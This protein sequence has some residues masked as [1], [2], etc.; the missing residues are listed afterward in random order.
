VAA[1]AASLLPWLHVKMLPAALA[2][3][4]VAVARLRGRPRV[5]FAFTAGLMA[6]LFALYYQIVFGRP[7]PL[8]IY[9]GIPTDVSGS[10]GRAVAGLGLDRSFGLLT[11]APLFLL[12]VPGLARLFGR[13]RATWPVLFVAAAVLLPVLPWRMWWGGQCPPG[14]F[15]VPL[16]P[17]LALA[18]GFVAAGER[19][20]LQRWRVPL[21]ALGWALGVYMIHD[22]G[23]L[24]LLNRANRPSRLWT[25]LSADV[26]VGPYLPSLTLP[27]PV[28]H[29]VAA[30][31]AA[32]L[33][34]VLLLHVLAQRK[35]AFDR[36]FRSFALPVALLVAV[37]AAVDGWARRGV[38][39][40]GAAP[41]SP[42]LE[43]SQAS[44]GPA[45]LEGSDAFL[46]R[47][48]QHDNRRV[49]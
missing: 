43:V 13:W 24:L 17:V 4:L 7:T 39:D 32:A 19:R 2:L 8:A 6:I 37:G 20:G 15:L 3:G 34:L 44:P 36:V 33:G 23:A 1:A 28:E 40:A 38:P 14:R 5:A 41:E 47:P 49:P 42:A 48:G 22:P 45:G 16:L 9:G 10:P 26:A 35:D 11:H 31:W 25:A 21:S 46:S 30:V 29:R 27:D 12:A 18:V